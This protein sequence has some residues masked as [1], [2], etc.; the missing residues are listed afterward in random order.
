VSISKDFDEISFG[1]QESVDQEFHQVEAGDNNE[2]TRIKTK[3]NFLIID[4][5]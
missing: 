3:T 2:N 4:E 1:F 5:I